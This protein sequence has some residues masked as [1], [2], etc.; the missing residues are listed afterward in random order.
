[1]HAFLFILGIHSIAEAR[2]VPSIPVAAQVSNK[3]GLEVAMQRAQLAVE[4]ASILVGQTIGERSHRPDP[5]SREPA[6][7]ND[8]G[9]RPL[10]AQD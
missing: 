8:G 9:K 6:L 2:D 5:P 3:M 10:G 7:A 1:M 4:N